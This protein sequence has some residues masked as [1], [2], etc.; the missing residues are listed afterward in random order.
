MELRVRRRSRKLRTCPKPLLKPACFGCGSA[1]MHSVDGCVTLYIL[2][3]ADDCP[4][5]INRLQT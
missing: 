4:T 5:V 3:G 2:S 1:Y